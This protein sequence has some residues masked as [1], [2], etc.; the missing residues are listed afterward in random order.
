VD[1]GAWFISIVLSLGMIVGFALTFVPFCARW[2]AY[3]HAVSIRIDLPA[4][5]ERTVAARLMARSRGG[6][7]GGL[8]F[9]V[10]AALAFHFEIGVNHDSQLTG[11][12][13]VGST[14]AGVAAGTAVAAL[15][16][17]RTIAPDRP[18]VA[19][20]RAV[21]VS[22]YLAPFERIGAR[23]VVYGAVGVLLVASVFAAPGA[24]GSL[25]AIAFFAI[26]GAVS[27]A[28]FEVASRRIVDRS[29]PAGSTAEL[30]WDDAIRASSL[31][32][33]VTAPLALGAYCLVFGVFGI[34]E[35]STH[36]AAML[37]SWVVG[38]IF[39]L[40]GLAAAIYS[41]ATR[42]QRYFVDRLWSDLR[43][44]DLDLV[45]EVA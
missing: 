9:T 41:I 44:S 42:P 43:A 18:R 31:R 45:E 39:G 5:L 30:V 16:G 34:A 8:V 29:Q 33:L 4:H 25:F 10:A 12:F 23:I 6:S 27:L 32:D 22:D 14:F 15:S 17:S 28:L 19:R 11:L 38:S 35:S 21:T 26:F 7:L 2:S 1:G 3:R 40:T 20:A 13:I 36:P 24:G 37:V